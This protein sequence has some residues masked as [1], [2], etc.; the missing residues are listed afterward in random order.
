MFRKHIKN[1][2]E[3]E[4]EPEF[5][6]RGKEASRIEGV[7]DAVFAFSVTLLVVSLE[8]PRS[9][10]ELMAVFDNFFAFVISIFALFG[11][12]YEHYIFF[13]RYGL[14]DRTTITLNA[15]LLFMVLFYIYPLKFLC[16]LLNK[17]IGGIFKSVFLNQPAS[18]T[19]Q[20]ISSMIGPNDIS[21][22]MILFGMGA[23][24]VFGLFCLLYHNALKR[25]EA[26][27]L[28]AIEV[29][30]TRSRF[31]RNLFFTVV[32]LIS[33]LIALISPDSYTLIG[34]VY[35]LLWF[36]WIIAKWEKKALAKARQ[37]MQVI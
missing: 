18:G 32:P 13:L 29:I 8:V 6:Y 34:P 12:W 35:G 14:K 9:F 31:Y 19:I 5:R 1:K 3:L 21:M 27:Q 36:G 22:L 11:I 28:N 7:S 17:L 16:I 15:L 24:G 23:A 25:K 26:L 30:Y 4:T 37:E 20:D 10:N 33:V 2:Y